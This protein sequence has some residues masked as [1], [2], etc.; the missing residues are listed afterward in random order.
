M[1]TTKTERNIKWQTKWT[2][3]GIEFIVLFIFWVVLSGRF[4]LKYL[5][6][7]MVAAGLVT[8]LTH[9]FIYNPRSAKKGPGT[10]YMFACAFRMILY[11]PWLVL[12]IIKANIQVAGILI[13]PH[14]PIDPV[15][16]KF[17]TKLS[18]RVSLVTLANSITLTPGTITIE[19][20]NGKYIV[21]SLVRGCAGDL[22]TGLMQNKV[23]RIFDDNPEITSPS[24]S[25][26]H[27]LKELEQ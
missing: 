4:Q 10:K 19:L 5:I 21:H 18:K 14:M 15:L 22:E 20:E 12:A 2:A 16:L 27:S 11:F 26:A 23:A 1:N 9:E 3:I 7:G 6:M 13:K 8:Y 24:C 25:W 17:E